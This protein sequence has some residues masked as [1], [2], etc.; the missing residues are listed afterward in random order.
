MAEIDWDLWNEGADGDG[1]CQSLYELSKHF[2][3][4]V[5]LEIGV[6]FGKSAYSTLK[7][8]PK[9]K[10]YGIDPDPEYPVEDF[11]EN[12]GMKNRFIFIRDR[13]PEALSQFKNETFDWIYIDGLHD[14]DGVFMDFKG[15]W[16][17]LKK[18]GVMIFDDYDFELGY[19]TGVRQML[20]E[21]TKEITGKKFVH[22]TMADYG[23]HPNPHQAAILIKDKHA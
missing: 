4:A 2:K 12:H 16:P 1:Y 13:S 18:G 10:L 22:K 21:R 19:G 23:C 5:G 17:L 20:E 3:P 8:S 15:C 11:M 7:G 14:Y 9:L 6:R